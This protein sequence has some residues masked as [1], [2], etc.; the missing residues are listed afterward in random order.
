MWA[1]GSGQWA[2]GSGQWAVGSGRWALR[3]LRRGRPGPGGAHGTGAPA[4]RRVRRGPPPTSPGHRPASPPTGSLPRVGKE[5]AAE[6][7]FATPR[8]AG[9]AGAH[10]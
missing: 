2:V 3:P 4:H 5:P 10:G 8:A 7:A 6:T 9:P 1:V